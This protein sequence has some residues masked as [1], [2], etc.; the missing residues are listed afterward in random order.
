MTLLSPGFETK[1]TTLSTTIVQSATGR[2]AL[3][4]K[5]QWGPADQ[6]Y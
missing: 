6:I 5:F 2:A 3:V 1:E 4:G